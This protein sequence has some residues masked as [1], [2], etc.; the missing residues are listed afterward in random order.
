M[1]RITTG[2]TTRPKEHLSRA[3]VTLHYAALHLAF[4]SVARFS[5]TLLAMTRCIVNGKRWL[6]FITGGGGSGY[7]IRRGFA[8]TSN[9]PHRGNAVGH[10]NERPGG[11]SVSERRAMLVHSF[12]CR[13]KLFAYKRRCVISL[14]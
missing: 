4:G 12:Q 3:R 6:M 11:M 7:S 8:V 2:S 13:R 14:K 5:R 1:C 10:L 9:S